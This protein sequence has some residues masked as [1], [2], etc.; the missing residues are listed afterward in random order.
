MCEN[1][2]T[3]IIGLGYSGTRYLR[4]FKNTTVIDKEKIQIAYVS[5]KNKDNNYIFYSN[6]EEA[7]KLYTP[8]IIVICV[9]DGEHYNVIKK[10]S[11]FSGFVICEKPLVNKNDNLEN[12]ENCLKSISG[13]C[14][15]MVERYSDTSIELKR[16][17][18]DNKLKLLRV[19]FYWGKDRIHDTRRTCGVPSEIIHALDLIQ[20]VTS[21]KEGIVIDHA[22]GVTSDFSISGKDI[23]DSIAITGNI[24]GAAVSGYSS[25]VNI[26]RKRTIDFTL[27]LSD[28]EIIYAHMEFDTP[29]WDIDT[30]KVWT[31]GSTDNNYIFNFINQW[32]DAS[33]DKCAI[34]KLQRQV[35]D[36]IMYCLYRERPKI[37]FA[38]LQTAIS[39]QKLLNNIEMLSKNIQ[40]PS[41][42][43]NGKR[44]F[45]PSEDLEKQG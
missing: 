25:F 15:D 32:D 3:L 34:Q 11:S 31:R 24:N 5:K 10:L 9:T 45:I 1:M 35:D 26:M 13:F 42:L 2:K 23:L 12:V 4:A 33:L 30:L 38:D 28:E 36:V 20:W 21:S 37:K 29:N 19:N 44:S 41:Y 8:D 22:I 17:I 7:L 40:S 18:H 27:A 6:I 43:V 39:L 16:F 14:M